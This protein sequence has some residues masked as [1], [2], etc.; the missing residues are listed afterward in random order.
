VVTRTLD[1]RKREDVAASRY[2]S[3]CVLVSAREGECYTLESAL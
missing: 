2:D 3:Y 1:Y